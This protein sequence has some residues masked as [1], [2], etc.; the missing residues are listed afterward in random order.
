MLSQEAKRAGR[1]A[2]AGAVALWL[3]AWLVTGEQT[4]WPRFADDAYYYFVVADHW[5]AGRGLSMDGVHFTNGFQ[6]LWMVLCLGIFALPLEPTTTLLALA[7]LATLAVWGLGVAVVWQAIGARALAPGLAAIGLLCFPRYLHIALAGM[8]SGLALL[9]AGLVFLRASRDDVLIRPTPTRADAQL[10]V[11]VGLLL[12]TRL[13]AVWMGLALAA[14]VG[15][16]AWGGASG[17]PLARL[18]ATWRKGWGT[19]WPVL[20]LV[21]PY[22]LWN[23]LV[24]GHVVPISGILK[25]TFPAVGPHPAGIKY[26]LLHVALVAPAALTALDLAWQGRKAAAWALGALV[27]GALVHILET[28]L[29]MGWAVLPTHFGTFQFLGAFGLGHLVARVGERALWP[30]RGAAL[31]VGGLSLAAM[32]WSLPK[33]DRGFALTA[34]AA[35]RWARAQLPE[36]AFLAMKDSGVFT[37]FAQRRVANLDG[38]ISDL[39][40]QEDLCH[41][42][43]EEH[44][45]AAGVTH[46]VQHWSPLPGYG[47]HEQVYPCHLAGGTPGKLD[48]P[49]SAEVYRGEPYITSLGTGAVVIWRAPWA[50]AP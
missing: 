46:V 43:L 18:W 19:F 48:L 16:H 44:L 13:D 25:S 50:P 3:G 21:I 27:L 39:A 22:L 20:A 32:A 28:F 1:G 35:G 36:D 38:I 11:L 14:V 7:Q 34:E 10:G 42:R 24:F 45:R 49:E 15:W 40:Y 33:G 31:A 5:W 30:A 17:S 4:F 37:F 9:L 41:G 23:E 2:F 6:P 47:V 29:F 8:E 12:L 26:N